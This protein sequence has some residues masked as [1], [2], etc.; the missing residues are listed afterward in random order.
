MTIKIFTKDEDTVISGNAVKDDGNA[1]TQSDIT[2]I[3][4]LRR[5]PRNDPTTYSAVIATWDTPGT[6]N[7]FSGTISGTL[8]TE[9]YWE[10]QFEYRLT[11]TSKPVYSK[12]Y[13]EYVGGTLVS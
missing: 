9:G 7:A 12:I 2:Q 6:G 11:S 5:G 8:P 1:Y 4:I 13:H 10:F 3:K